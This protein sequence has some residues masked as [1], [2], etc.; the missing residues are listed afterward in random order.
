LILA[1][2]VRGGCG[3]AGCGCGG[4]GDEEDGCEGRVELGEGEDFGGGG[5]RWVFLGGLVGHFGFLVL[6]GGFDD[7]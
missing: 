7:G 4:G 5:L 1:V 6:Y 2:L 3:G